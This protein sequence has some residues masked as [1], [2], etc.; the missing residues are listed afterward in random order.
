MKKIL[1]L[2]LLAALCGCS[3]NVKPDAS[4]DELELRIKI[5]EAQNRITEITCAGLSNRI[6]KIQASSSATLQDAESR[7]FQSDDVEQGSHGN[8]L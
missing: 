2:L 8:V 4:V 3:K 5:L 6:A 7:Q 1:P